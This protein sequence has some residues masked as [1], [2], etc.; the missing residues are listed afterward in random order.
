MPFF[1]FL[2]STD[3]ISPPK[4]NYE[5]W[6]N[7]EHKMTTEKYLSDGCTDEWASERMTQHQFTAVPLPLCVPRQS[8]GSWRRSCCGACVSRATG[9]LWRTRHV[10][11]LWMTLSGREQT[12]KPTPSLGKPASTQ[13]RSMAADVIIHGSGGGREISGKFKDG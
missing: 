5:S 7:A 2:P 11:R 8:R 13:E 12:Q 10:S 1:F 3:I 9:T 6:K 4:F